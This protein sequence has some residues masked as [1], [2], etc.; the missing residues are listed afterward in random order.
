MDFAV[1]AE[2]LTVFLWALGFIFIAYLDLFLDNYTQNFFRFTSAG[3]FLLFFS[4]LLNKEKYLASFKN[5]RRLLV[6]TVMVF[7]YQI[8]NVYGIALTTPTIGTLVTRLSVI[9]V[10]VLSFF[11]FSEEKAI[12]R[13]KGF[14]AGTGIAL[15]GVF[16]VILSGSSLFYKDGAIV[17]FY[18]GILSLL[19][20][21][22]LWAA[23]IISAKVLLEKVDPLSATTSIFLVSGFMYLPF[24]ILSN[25]FFKIFEVGSII[26]V[27][28][29]ISGILS[30][31][32]GNLLNYYAM[33][34][35]GASVST[36]LQLLIPLFTA[37]LS[38][39]FFGEPM[40]FEKIVSSAA[41]LVGCWFIVRSGKRWNA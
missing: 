21:A 7:A 35:L 26:I 11:L 23:Y 8:F 17:M 3:L 14:L 25:G 20:T 40:P 36:N 9:F 18:L 22:M 5:F 1:P 19:V 33:Q 29:V 37:I 13:D 6:P 2:L 4:L 31:G 27:Y 38:V 28:L 32:I 34:K 16:G 15:V 24:S 10:D 12:I 30:I 41:T 39:V